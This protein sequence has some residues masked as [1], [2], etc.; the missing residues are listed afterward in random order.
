MRSILRVRTL[1]VAS[2]VALAAAACGHSGGSSGTA[3]GT[4]AASAS[5]AGPTGSR[6]SHD[7]I[8]ALAAQFRDQP[9]TGGQ[10]AP[11]LYRWVNDKVLMFLQFDNADPANATVLRYVGVAVK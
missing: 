2:A 4:P 6:L 8:T 1:A 3:A 7:D 10:V 11:R 5:A 9:L